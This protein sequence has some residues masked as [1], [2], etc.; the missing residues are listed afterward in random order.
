MPSDRATVVSERASPSWVMVILA[1]GRTAPD[2]SFTVPR[3]VPVS[4]WARADAAASANASTRRG[5]RLKW[6]MLMTQLL[7]DMTIG[8]TLVHFLY[9]YYHNNKSQARFLAVIGWS[10]STSEA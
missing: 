6:R 7:P 10:Q 3:I 9:S 1:P 5:I 8:Q 2:V 4:T